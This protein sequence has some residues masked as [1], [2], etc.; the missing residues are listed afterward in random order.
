MTTRSPIDAYARSVVD[1][2]IPAGQYHRGAC[3]RFLADR[4]RDD[5]VFDEAAAERAIAFFPR[6]RHYK[7]QWAG[8]PIQLEPWQQF[9]VGQLFGWRE[10][11]GLRRFRSAYVEV[12]RKNGKT[13]LAA[14]IGLYTTFFDA[15]PGAEGY[16][17]ATTRDQAYLVFRD[18][19][20]L[21]QRTPALAHRVD[22]AGKYLL[23]RG[24]AQLR[25]LSAKDDSL[26]GLSPH[27]VV[28][29]EY[30]AH[31]TRGLYDVLETALGA[32]EQ[33]LFLTITTAGSDPR[34]P[35]GELHDHACRVLDT[36]VT[37]DRL[38]AFIAHADADD[39]PHAEATWRKANPNLGVSVLVDDMLA[40]SERAR[41]M[42]SAL[43][44][45]RQKRLNVWVEAASPWLHIE[46]WQAGQSTWDRAPVEGR[47]CWGGLDLAAKIDLAAFVLLFLPEDDD[48]DPRWQLLAWFFT[49]AQ[50][51]R[52]RARRWHVPLQRWVDDGLVQVTPGA[53]I[54]HGAIR[55]AVVDA[56]DRF[57][58]ER[59]GF[60]PWNIGNFDHELQD[61][62]GWDEDRVVEVPQSFARLTW[63]SKEFEAEVAAGHVDAGGNEVLA[64]MAANV[65][66]DQDRNEN[67]KPSKDPKKL[68]GRIDGIVATVIA[69]EVARLD[70]AV[71]GSPYTAERGIQT[72][73]L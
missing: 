41:S 28:I 65:T 2:A 45:F 3:R 19:D 54:H 43:T 71:G 23:R 51:L 36:A 6:L 60:D 53:R 27:L 30:H 17:A 5:L 37:D 7:G 48:A 4:E 20:L 39:D 29:D 18:A 67:I 21:V 55:D 31:R 42:P 16:C 57:R 62:L 72:V 47:R 50:G 32:R 69:R 22:R 44:S 35:C 46:A 58:I 12:P 13:L 64:W 10:S 26:D 68:R 14:V 11:G 1:G 25:T 73:A 49:P 52:D 70:E 59:V 40:L 8:T 34:S 66:V 15:E 9:L 61:V 38:L 56:A 33:P 24:A 63:A